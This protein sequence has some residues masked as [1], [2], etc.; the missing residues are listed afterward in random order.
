MVG[1]KRSGIFPLRISDAIAFAD[2]NPT[3]FASGHTWPL[4]GVLKPGNNARRFRPMAF[5]GF[6]IVRERAVERV[7][8]RGETY[9]NVVAATGSIRLVGAAIILCP[10]L[11]PRTCAIGHWIVAARFLTNP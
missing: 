8:P 5:P 6:V 7:L 11:V 2:C 1:A 10:I 9:R 3:I 4:I